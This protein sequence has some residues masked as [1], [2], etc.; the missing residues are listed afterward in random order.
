MKHIIETLILISLGGCATSIPQPNR[1]WLPGEWVMMDGVLQY[2]LA[3]GAHGPITYEADGT[4]FLW[5]EAGAWRLDSNVLTETMT[6]F[7]PLHIDRSDADIG[8]PYVSTLRWIDR[9]RFS[10]RFADGTTSEF[11]RCPERG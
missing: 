9:N 2:P 1:D 5:G 7:E 4:Y 6:G 8:K 10:K 11:R 3:C